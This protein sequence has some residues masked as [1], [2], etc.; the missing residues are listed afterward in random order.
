VNIV[1]V[2]ESDAKKKKDWKALLN[3]Q[4]IALH[5]SSPVGRIAKFGQITRC[6]LA[7]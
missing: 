1:S 4:D 7:K 5:H 6:N 2:S 3:Q